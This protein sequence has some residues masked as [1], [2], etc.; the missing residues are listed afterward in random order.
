MEVVKGLK[1][2]PSGLAVHPKKGLIFWAEGGEE[3]RIVRAQMDGSNQEVLFH[4]RHE[5]LSP[6][7]LTLD[8]VRDR[9]YWTDTSLHR[10]SSANLDGS[11][12]EVVL[13]DLQHLHRPGSVSVLEDWVYWTDVVADSTKVTKANK[14]SGS[15][16]V[17]LTEARL[18][19][20]ISVKAFH[21]VLQPQWPDLCQGKEERCPGLCVPHLATTTAC[22]CPQNSTCR[23][24]VRPPASNHTHVLE[25]EIEAHQ[26]TQQK[27]NYII[28]LIIGLIGASL[29]LLI[30]VSLILESTPDTRFKTSR[31]L[32]FSVKIPRVV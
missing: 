24:K 20:Q 1:S 32:F 17:T 28:V 15:G 25:E 14:F 10:I 9:I 12:V 27:E 29:V 7:G 6:A 23:G 18:Q 4:S 26:S 5:V 13:S 30:L 21:S 31:F 2:A 16:V 11:S 19:S 22:L 3:G 8:L